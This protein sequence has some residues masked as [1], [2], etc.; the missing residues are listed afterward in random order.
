MA[1]AFKNYAKGFHLRILI[2]YSY[3]MLVTVITCVIL[4]SKTGSLFSYVKLTIHSLS[5]YGEIAKRRLLC[6][7]PVKGQAVEFIIIIC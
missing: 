5:C 1:I 2:M 4:L 6:T 3:C 7:K